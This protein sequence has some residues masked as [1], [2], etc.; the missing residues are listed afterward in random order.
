MLFAKQAIELMYSFKNFE[1]MAKIAPFLMNRI[2]DRHNR[3]SVVTH[4]PKGQRALLSKIAQKM[5]RPAYCFNYWN[6]N[7]HYELNLAN[8][9]ER[10]IAVTLFVWNKEASKKILAGERADR[11]QMGN[12]SWFRNERYNSKAFIMQPEWQVPYNGVF[13]FDYMYLNDELD[14]THVVPDEQL[15]VLLDWFRARAEED[16]ADPYQLALAFQG[17]SD[18]LTFRSDQLGHFVDLIDGKP[19]ILN[20]T[21]S[22]P[23]LEN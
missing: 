18:F 21:L 17:I 23:S 16:K 4:F 15:Q 6:P 8:P 14:P 10:D 9:I 22:R 2:V 5:G 20:L 19:L 7:G 12:K 13:E 1:A 3:F 11:S